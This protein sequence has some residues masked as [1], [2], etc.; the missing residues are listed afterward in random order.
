M[1]LHGRLLRSKKKLEQKLQ[2]KQAKRDK[3]GK[4]LFDFPNVTV[5]LCLWSFA[6]P[7]LILTILAHLQNAFESVKTFSIFWGL[8]GLF[9]AHM[10]T[11]LEQRWFT[12]YG[13]TK[14]IKNEI[15]WNKTKGILIYLIC[16]IA[17]IVGGMLI[18]NTMQFTLFSVIS[19]L[20][21]LY[22]ALRKDAILWDLPPVRILGFRK[23]NFK[24][25][26]GDNHAFR[27]GSYTCV[28][29]IKPEKKN[30]FQVEGTFLGN[31]WFYLRK[32]EEVEEKEEDKTENEVTTNTVSTQ[33]P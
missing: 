32:I 31:Q 4:E 11:H 33:N 27:G 15:P 8:I 10:I 28:T 22:M 5:P 12:H 26:H 23:Y 20:T 29:R 25:R 2:E 19:G 1:S 3:L 9:G 30:I 21:C 7:F 17:I 18:K 24:P 16:N 13:D 14:I 6:I